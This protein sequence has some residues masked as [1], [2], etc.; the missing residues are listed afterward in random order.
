METPR[1]A[2]NFAKYLDSVGY[3]NAGLAWG[4]SHIN[5]FS[6]TDHDEIIKILTGERQA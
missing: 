1:W 5:E 6:D 4:L 2:L 3:E